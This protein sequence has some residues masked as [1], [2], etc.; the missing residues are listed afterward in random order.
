[1]TARRR[2]AGALFLLYG[3]LLGTWTARIPAIKARLDLSDARL[4]YCLLAFA[5]GAIVG[6]Q[7]SGWLVDRVGAPAV[8]V[9][10]VLLDSVALV[11]P[12]YAG[13][14]ALL[15]VALLCFG[16]VHGVLN[17][18]MNVNAV[19]VQRALGRPIIS[20][21][22]AIY[23]I[24]GFVGAAVGGL[25][26]YGAVGVRAN[27]TTVAVVV[28]VLG[29]CLARWIGASGVPDEAE[30]PPSSMAPVSGIA[31]LGVLA[32]CCL[33]GEGAAADWSS[34]YL[35]D[36]LGT[37]AGYAAAAYACFAVM[38]TAGRLLGDGLVLRFGPVAVARAGGW[39]AAL[40]LAGCLLADEP[41]AGVA[42]FGALGAGLS[43][44]APQVF[45]AAGN[46]NPDR[47]GQA[48]GRVAGLG[49]LGFVVGPVI[50]GA[51]AQVTGIAWALVVPA[52]LA[53][54]VAVSASALSTPPR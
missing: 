33:V 16:L 5:A 29:L 4:S 50:I 31:F 45:A 9:P 34:V 37:S 46:R 44:I 2:S 36:G 51:M 47:S 30:T 18:A 14:L 52:L 41:L 21:C 35:R 23:S 8:L 42:G 54:F 19:E 39:L 28:A 3:V 53:A 27:F 26:A 1:M 12:S 48:I 43:C 24:G 13:G 22:H 49:F 11:A 40:G 10:A 32:F 25:F 15:A 6:M 20:T 17:V 38:M 7:V